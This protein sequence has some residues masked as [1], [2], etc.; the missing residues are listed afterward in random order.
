MIGAPRGT[1]L[2]STAT[3]LSAV[4]GTPRAPIG[5][6]SPGVCSQKKTTLGLAF[7]NR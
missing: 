3:D 4:I 2:R 5:P 1:N 7:I 6:V